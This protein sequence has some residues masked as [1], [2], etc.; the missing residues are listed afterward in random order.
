[1][2]SKF[3]DDDCL[4]FIF[5]YLKQ[6]KKKDTSKSTPFQHDYKFEKLKGNLG[7]YN[8]WGNFPATEFCQV[9]T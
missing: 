6:S 1:M 4:N 7:S 8:P 9:D 2:S 3:M 5:Y